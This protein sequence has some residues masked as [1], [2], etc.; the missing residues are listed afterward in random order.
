MAA[1]LRNNSLGK[2]MAVRRAA[3]LVETLARASTPPTRLGS[4]T[5]T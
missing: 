1:T 4:C 3:E 2:P 5:A